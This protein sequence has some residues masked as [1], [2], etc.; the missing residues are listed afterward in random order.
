MNP[1]FY[2]TL[3]SIT[4]NTTETADSVS[5]SHMVG[6]VSS[7]TSQTVSFQDSDP[8]EQIIFANAPH[9]QKMD[10][11]DIGL[12]K[13]LERPTLIKTVNWTEAAY[14]EDTF[15]P[16][17]LFLNNAYIKNK[18]Q[19]FHF[20]RGN[21]KVKI[22]MNA[23]PF[24]YGAMLCSYK[25]TPS[26]TLSVTTSSKRLIALSQRPHIW[27]YPQLGTAGE[28]T[29][30]F[31]YPYNYVDVTSATSVAQLGSLT[32][33][34]YAE[35]ASANGATSNGV[36]LQFY[37]WLE[38]PELSGQTYRGAMQAGD[39]EYGNGPVSA[40]AAAVAKFA[41][42][43][44][45]I[46]VIG[47]FA[48]A[49]TIGAS[50]VSHIAKLFG[51]SNV[52]VIEDVRPLK[53]L[54]FHD[55]PSAHIS[56]PT[57]KFTLDPKAELSV[58][59]TLVGGPSEDELAISYLVQRESFLT[60]STWATTDPIDK[61]YF[62][63]P[64]E[65][66]LIDI[67]SATAG[68][69][70]TIYQTPM[71]WVA[72]LFANW[73][74]DI[75]FRFKIVASKFHQGRLRIS[76]DPNTSFGVTTDTSNIITTKVVDISENDDVEFRVPYL[77]VRPWLSVY[78]VITSVFW[79]TTTKATGS[80]DYQNGILTVQC[81]TNLSA[82]VD[83]APVQILVFVRG[84]DNLEFG[85]PM[86]LD[87][88][89][90]CSH[91]TMQSGEVDYPST[92][93]P[94]RFLLN[95]GE[96]VPT[97]RL[98]LRRSNKVDVVPIGRKV[99]DTDLS[100]VVFNYMTKYPP[101]P[102]YDPNGTYTAKGVEALATT[103]PFTYSNMTTLEWVTAAFVGMRGSVRWHYNLDTDSAGAISSVEVR[104]LSN[105]NLTGTGLGYVSTYVTGD[106]FSQEASKLNTLPHEHNGSGGVVVNNLNTQT[107]ISFEMPQ[108]AGTRFYYT[109]PNLWANGSYV[110]GSYYDTYKMS[111]VVHP[112][113]R[114]RTN[115]MTMH[116]YCCA[117]TDF[118]VS[119]FLNV[120]PLYINTGMGTVPV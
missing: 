44:H 112:Q 32:L 59:P 107:G 83:V 23:A 2:T 74:G 73:H 95:F 100:G 55:I 48:K 93:E 29:L 40:P 25:P 116:R 56:E 91:I 80:Q 49:T 57:P 53:N 96:P 26:N 61:I 13:F 33:T 39:D 18:L 17:S 34:T 111:V 31:I 89:A 16:W 92:Q 42:H 54:P 101:P 63:C 35:L 9:D 10:R 119:F 68:G 94:E 27:I 69:T 62:S 97:L 12:H 46:P 15:D 118:S 6:G 11:K 8:G 76:W 71:A 117:G 1:T 109:N 114:P 52:P 105:Y 5:R 36:T 113:A 60:S 3:A 75:I 64:V 41:K 50:A 90:K 98:L 38:N 65:P 88:F 110:D 115:L 104:R 51:W 78:R 77:Q 19:N 7:L 108:M 45:E 20:L 103:F 43:F 79:S 84:A 67:S 21:L 28:V 120:P 85:N 47:N 14:T 106:T 102:G 4:A 87:D 86:E 58:D 72:S 37:A 81:L 82:P 99:V 24:Y 22:V 66:Y 30:P 70:R